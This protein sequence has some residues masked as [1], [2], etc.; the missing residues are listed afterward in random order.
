MYII[1]NALGIFTSQM[2]FLSDCIIFS[3][4]YISI[5]LSAIAIVT[6]PQVDI[7]IGLRFLSND[8]VVHEN[9]QTRQLVMDK[10]F[11]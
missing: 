11:S 8:E 9:A 5:C 3:F 1:I 6:P 10:K 2:Y 7:V 4:Y